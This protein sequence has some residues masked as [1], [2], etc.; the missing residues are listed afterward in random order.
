M[1]VSLK[2]KKTNKRQFDVFKDTVKLYEDFKMRSQ[3]HSIVG[4]VFASNTD[5]LK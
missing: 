3:S 1:F 5:N 4:R 2:K